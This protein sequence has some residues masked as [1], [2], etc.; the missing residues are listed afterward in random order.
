[1]EL[2]FDTVGRNYAVKPGVKR[3]EMYLLAM[4]LTAILL[5]LIMPFHATVGELLVMQIKR[6]YFGHILLFECKNRVLTCIFIKK[7]QVRC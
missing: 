5:E 2:F 6:N 1:M 7:M 4:T 3:A